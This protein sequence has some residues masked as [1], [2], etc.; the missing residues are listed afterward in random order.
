MEQ[1]QAHSSEAAELAALRAETG[2]DAAG[3]RAAVAQWRAQ[4]EEAAELARLRAET[5]LDASALRKV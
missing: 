5:G 1:W 2:L 3:I 4:K